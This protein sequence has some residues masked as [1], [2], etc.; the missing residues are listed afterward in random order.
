MKTTGHVVIILLL[1]PVFHF[2]DENRNHHFIDYMED[3][4][5]EDPAK[6]L[7]VLTSDY[8]QEE[9][10]LDFYMHNLLYK[11]K[12]KDKNDVDISEDTI[13]MLAGTYFKEKRMKEK[14]AIA[15]YYSARVFLEK[16]NFEKSMVYLLKAEDCLTKTTNPDNI[17]MGLIFYYQGYLFVEQ[18]NYDKAIQCYLSSAHFFQKARDARNENYADIALASIYLL[19]NDF[20]NALYHS[21]KTLQFAR[22]NHDSLCLSESLKRT[23]SIYKHTESPQVAKLLF[24]EALTIRTSAEDMILKCLFLSETYLALDQ[25]DSAVYY[26]SL[27]QDDINGCNDFIIKAK[28]YE[29]LE[30]QFQLWGDEK[31]ALSNAR[32]VHLYLDSAMMGA[33]N[34][35]ITEIT[36]KYHAA[37]NQ[38]LPQL[39]TIQHSVLI[40]LI[41]LLFLMAVLLFLT[42]IFESKRK[43][44]TWVV[45][46]RQ[47]IDLSHK[48]EKV[49]DILYQRFEIAKKLALIQSNPSNNDRKLISKINEI[50]YGSNDLNYNWDEFY[51]LFNEFNDNMSIK[52][53]QSYSQLTPEEVHLCCLIRSGYTTK[54]ICAILNYAPITIRM[55]ET[56]IRKKL[57]ISGKGSLISFLE[58]LCNNHT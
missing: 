41:M 27:F 54:N 47:E 29:Y 22:K 36:E 28:Y 19:I 3:L 39:L 8:P 20:K 5:E 35:S 40:I 48:K 43:K 44:E 21:S 52:L 31:S 12:S 33:K 58:D 13:I 10:D 6:A 30:Q 42:T 4:I 51:T 50:F 25:P 2:C 23:G 56:N 18:A 45:G 7:E 38:L 16:K 9:F 17:L 11:L 46:E 1:V 55:R 57:G 26:I 49:R 34:N 14:T 24:L 53:G 32:L 15:Y 37:K